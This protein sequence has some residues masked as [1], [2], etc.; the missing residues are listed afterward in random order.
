MKSL[1]S[2]FTLLLVLLV[3][4][5]AAHAADNPVRLYL[6][7]KELVPEVPPRLEEGNTLVP[8]RIIAEGL[9]SKVS[10]DGS[11]QKVTVE[12]DVTRIE[13]YIGNTRAYVN[14]KEYTLEKAP[15]LVAGNTLL[16]VR[17]VSE[18]LGLKVTWD[19][20][21][22]SV[23]LDSVPAPASGGQPE[24]SADSEPAGGDAGQAPNPASSDPGQ[25]SGG[26]N[27]A[28]AYPG[29]SIGGGNGSAPD[30]GGSAAVG[31][32]EISNSTGS[33][34]GGSQNLGDART[35]RPNETVGQVT[36]VSPAAI[37]DPKIPNIRSI[38]L[39][40]DRLYIQANGQVEAKLSYLS[41]PDRAVIDLPNSE[42]DAA[43]N[44]K[45]AVQ[46]GEVAVLSSAAVQKIRYALYSDKPST[47]R[48]VL[49]LKARTDVSPVAS[50]IANQLVFQLK[51][52]KFKVVLDAGHGG[53]DPGAG[54]ISGKDEKDFTLSMV[55]K[56]KGLL[57]REPQIQAYLTRSDDT[58]VGLDE[59][60]DLANQLGADVFISIHGNKY[61]PNVSG[62]ETY[63][64]RDDG[65]VDLANLIHPY[66]LKATGFTDRGVR[67]ADFR[68]IKKTT[69][70]AVLLEIGYLSNAGD[71]A[72]M[73]SED[74]QNRVAGAIVVAI[75]D[76]LNIK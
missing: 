65:S 5:V 45:R 36:P 25:N 71:E 69:M 11:T 51:N 13:L 59:R 10:W 63:Y 58:Y 61:T 17:F 3:V 46:N 23:F 75:K 2:V 37:D 20:I 41:N 44:G 52:A 50:N 38:R 53:Y 1:L 57:D 15:M 19:Q 54:S 22:Q 43:I 34:S 40:G 30:P 66:L 14:G 33:P 67:Q 49:D 62:E 21:T 27:E 39:I 24:N 16:P 70:P 72:Q 68:V 76:F 29:Q 73:Y 12:K 9:G 55:K 18:Q 47:V 60:A 42:L 4:P 48:V 28:A 64:C 6:N 7:G 31:A 32:G 8:V 26:G 56:V 74:F 35:G